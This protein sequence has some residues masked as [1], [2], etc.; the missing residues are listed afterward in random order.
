[1][2]VVLEKG[3][4]SRGIDHEDLATSLTR[5]GGTF[6]RQGDRGIICFVTLEVMNDKILCINELVD[7]GHEVTWWLHPPHESSIRALGW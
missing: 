2:E 5:P 4:P 1:V 6:G 3:R 7:V